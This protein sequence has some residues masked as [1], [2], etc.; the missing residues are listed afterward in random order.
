MPAA[1][2]FFGAL[3]GR[4]SAQKSRRTPLAPN[5]LQWS[6]T[7][8]PIS[9]PNRIEKAGLIARFGADQP[10]KRD[11]TDWAVQSNV[12][13]SRAKNER[14]KPRSRGHS[15]DPLVVGY[16]HSVTCLHG[17]TPDRTIIFNRH[18]K[19]KMGKRQVRKAASPEIIRKPL[20]FC[21]VARLIDQLRG[22]FLTTAIH[23]PQQQHR[24]CSDLRRSHLQKIRDFMRPTAPDVTLDISRHQVGSAGFSGGG[25]MGFS[26]GSSSPSS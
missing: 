25:A 23:N 16:P 12:N 6:N 15:P 17:R 13:P 8:P 3:L 1:N 4:S 26:M 11:P 9:Q 5:L 18:G 10:A 20:P 22:M 21:G 7:G 24:Y 14:R 2:L 19:S